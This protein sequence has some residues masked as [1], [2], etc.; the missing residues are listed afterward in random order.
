MH[1]RAAVAVFGAK[2]SKQIVTTKVKSDRIMSLSFSTAAYWYAALCIGQWPIDF[3]EHATKCDDRTRHSPSKDSNA[4]L[5][6]SVDSFLSQW[7]DQQATDLPLLYRDLCQ[8]QHE[9]ATEGC[10]WHSNSF[11]LGEGSPGG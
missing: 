1:T 4:D 10:P 11:T 2:A 9:F 5:S 8:Q 7:A 3:P 6:R